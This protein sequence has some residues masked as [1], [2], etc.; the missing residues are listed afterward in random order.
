M[1]TLSSLDDPTYEKFK[2]RVRS[3]VPDCIVDFVSVSELRKQGKSTD[4]IADITS[5][6]FDDSPWPKTKQ[7]IE[8]SHLPE[9]IQKLAAQNA[10][11]PEH[12]PQ[13]TEQKAEEYVCSFLRG[14]REFGHKHNVMTEHTAKTI[15]QD[16]ISFFD[17]DKIFYEVN[18]GK[19]EW[20]FHNGTLI[21]DTDKAGV[22]H[23]VQND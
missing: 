13:M 17:A 21:V 6:Y 11:I 8:L 22:L 5:E 16:F 23:V 9:H 7:N 20:V 10:E 2:K 14:G 4:E 12:W 3:Y 15:W 19:P 1:V 18:L